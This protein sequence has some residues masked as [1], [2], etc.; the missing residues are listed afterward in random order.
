M[1]K[2]LAFSIVRV[3]GGSVHNSP[4][5]DNPD[6]GAPG[7][8]GSQMTCTATTCASDM[9]TV[10]DSGVVDHTEPCALGCFSDSTRC[11]NVSPSNGLA[12]TFDQAA[13][14]PAVSLPGAATSDS[15]PGGVMS[16]GTPVAVTSTTVAQS[17]G[18]TLR[19]LLEVV[20]D[21]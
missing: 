15:D 16:A 3:G 5:G 1:S 2:W 21:R 12:A 17:G 20:D 14:Q 7:D 11:N 8:T 6:G 18:P 19:V 9:L 13:Q 10:C 4:P